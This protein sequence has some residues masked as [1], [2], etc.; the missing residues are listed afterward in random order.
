MM[1]GTIYGIVG[2]GTITEEQLAACREQGRVI[3]RQSEGQVEVWNYTTAQWEKTSSA[4][5][6][7]DDLI[8]SAGVK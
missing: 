8:R 1:G 3:W 6:K 7:L 4:G 2:I 5:L